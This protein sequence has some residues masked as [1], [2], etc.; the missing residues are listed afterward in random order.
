MAE[1]TAGGR[2]RV[3]IIRDHECAGHDHLLDPG[4]IRAWLGKSVFARLTLAGL[5]SRP[6]VET[7]IGSASVAQSFG[8]LRSRSA[9]A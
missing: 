8:I 4:R 5:G 9:A 3:D 7:S 2:A 6:R 1:R